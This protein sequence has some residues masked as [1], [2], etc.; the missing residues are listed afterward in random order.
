MSFGPI[1]TN[2]NLKPCQE[3]KTLSRSIEGL[4]NLYVHVNMHVYVK[5]ENTDSFREGYVE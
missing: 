4:T 2:T 1:H 3:G 5:Q